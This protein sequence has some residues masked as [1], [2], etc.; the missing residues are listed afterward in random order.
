[1]P[2]SALPRRLK[3][4]SA[5][6]V[7]WSCLLA[8]AVLCPHAIALNPEW[9]IYQFGHRA[10]KIDDGYLGSRAEVFAQDKDG[11]LWVG[12]ANGL[13]RFD[14]I[15][16]T[17]WK[18]PGNSPSLGLVLSLLADRDGSLWI[19]T[20]NGVSHWDHRRLTHYK[21]R[22]G[23]FVYSLAQD[24]AGAIWFTPYSFTS[25]EEDVVCKVAS[26]KLTCFGKK[27]R[28][29]PPAPSFK[30]LR[31]ASGTLWM[32]RSDSILSWREGVTKIYDLKRL[33]NN[34]NQGGVTSLAV[35][36]DGSLFVGISKQ[37]P[38]LGLQRFRNGQL[39]TVIAP[40]FDG[41]RHR[42]SSLFV[43][44]HQALW[45]STF[46]EGI[47]RLYQG[48]VDHFGRLDGLSADFTRAVFEDR[49]GSIWVCTGEGVD[50][51]R[52]LA[53]RSFS[54]MAYPKAR[55]FDTLVTLPDG[56]MWIGGDGV[57]Y[58]LVNG[59]NRFISQAGVEGKQVTTI[60]GDRAGRVWVGLDNTLNLFSNGRFLPVKM[61]DG[62]PVGFIVS[63]TEDTSG[64]LFAITTSPTR[65]LLSID[66]K[67]L[68]AS[69]VFPALDASKIAAD[70]REGIWIGTNTGTIQHFSGGKITN[71]SITPQSGTR[72]AQLTVTPG[73]D[74]LA[75]GDFGL[76]LLTN[77]AV[78]VF[79]PANGLPCSYVN[80]FLFDANGSLWLYTACGLVELSA[81]ELQQWRENDR[82]QF[83]PRL[84][85]SS[86]GF[87]GSLPPF[88]GAARSADG[89]LWFN[90][91]QE[92]MMIDPAHMYG[93][94]TPP[95][96]HIQAIRADFVEHALAENM[97]LP[98]LTRDIEIDHAALSFVAPEKIRSRYR[99]SGFDQQ[100]HDVG[101]RRQAVYMN[102]K[103]GTY[104]FQV[105]AA[106]N[107]GIWNLQGDKLSFTI[108]PTF[109]ETSWFL[110]CLA[111]AGLL[112][113]YAIFI[114][115]LRVSTR[116]VEG[117]MNERLLERDRI[118][119]ELHDTLLQGFQGIV[120]RLHGTT[121]LLPDANPA[122]LS[123]EDTMDR[124]DQILV[125]GRRSLLQLRSRANTST[126]LAEQLHQI[127]ADLRTQN[128]IPCEILIRGQEHTL[129][130]TV[131][132]EVVSIV[133]E[134][135]TNAFRHSKA[136]RIVV[137]LDSTATHF[138]IVCRDNGVGLPS[139]VLQAG[140]AEG[141]WG[142]VGLRER[143]QNL[144]A[145]LV[146]RNNEPHG[147]VV[148]IVMS[149][150]IAYAHQRMRR[151][152][153]L[154]PRGQR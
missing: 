37:G 81:A 35:D 68:K 2:R 91:Q 117:R 22:A 88:E 65:T 145:R 107:D 45:I 12:T 26:E 72:I 43:D 24:G 36:S 42:V 98:R 51:L 3:L 69:A 148:E 149:A 104:F 93:N 146:L 141:H 147:T 14:G 101:S 130:P 95:P 119:R 55:E 52:D 17:Q 151:L 143:A 112:L 111:L 133:R 19:G 60:F 30:F 82:A 132:E 128:E 105:I 118:A 122:R 73:G 85:D 75:A 7:A 27:D 66:A 127:V 154:I 138:T 103:P 16:F 20:D 74:V 150:R 100:W 123:L 57:L 137:E 9:N 25:N 139:T 70:P 38:G 116:L 87:K 80:N 18:P 115:R 44:R 50:Q 71:Y 39:S 29:P 62:R 121:R 114:V 129:K 32:A 8:S 102:L 99:L 120:L 46:D 84:F 106:N 28:L 13:F 109:Y 142:L 135:L 89:R 34:L 31:D 125:D 15:Q 1:M 124:A 4:A 83:S 54:R 94:A 5:L 131:Q 33:R 126:G 113:I 47:Y 144:H 76:A 48:N 59:N 41:S 134:S 77:G 153:R 96:V 136:A 11:Y 108:P 23:Q 6:N 40:G 56:R 97:K 21:D 58:T 110:V 92:L 10:W 53:V 90:N 64:G 78:H 140:A 67:A 63:M 152:T 79:G 86:D 49:E 61:P